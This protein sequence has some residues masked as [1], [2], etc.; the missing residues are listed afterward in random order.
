MWGPGPMAAAVLV[1]NT[2]VLELQRSLPL[3]KMA[4]NI[5]NPNINVK[6]VTIIMVV[7]TGS[8]TQ[9]NYLNL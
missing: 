8:H 5:P 6:V 2:L 3:Y 1:I 9:C 4:V 7:N